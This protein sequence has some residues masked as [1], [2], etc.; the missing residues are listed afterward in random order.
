MA[1]IN[2]S[3][4][5]AARAIH[6]QQIIR[7]LRGDVTSV[8]PVTFTGLDS[9]SYSMT[10]RNRHTD[11]A[12]LAVYDSSNTTK[13]LDVVNAGVVVRG[14]TIASTY[15]RVRNFANNADIFAVDESGATVG[16]VGFVTLTG[17]QTLT[18]KTLTTP[19]LD[20]AVIDDYM[21]VNQPVS[22][23]AN[24]GASKLRLYGLSSDSILR[25]RNSAGT[26]V[27][28]LDDTS[29]QTA[30]NKTFTTPALVGPVVSDY[31]VLAGQGGAPTAPSA[32]VT[33]LYS[34]SADDK[35]YFRNSTIT[36]T[37]ATVEG[38]ETLLLKTLTAPTLNN[39]VFGDY[40][41]INARS[42]VI[43]TPGSGVAHVY[44]EAAGTVLKYKASS[45]TERTLV[46]TD[47]T[48]TLSNKTFSAGLALSTPTLTGPITANYGDW[49]WISSPGV[50]AAS[51]TR[52]FA[53]NDNNLYFHPY[54]GSET[55]LLTTANS[56]T[57]TAAGFARGLSLGSL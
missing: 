5:A 7:W 39:P 16:G 48:Q 29:T 51:Y 49:A 12:A 22:A 57:F 4:G 42:S 47:S 31:A 38:T 35:V 34:L 54:G 44:L 26:V 24:P 15:F 8:E 9:A 25:H 41:T 18:N 1:I 50:P 14:K 28:V 17:T 2:V 45:S 11:G 32:G 30:T 52:V 19:V 3:N 6:V 20:G 56:T 53:K 27:Q 46:D 21:D 55:L 10:L 36:R 33:R 23:P 13:L 43:P 37:L 40:S